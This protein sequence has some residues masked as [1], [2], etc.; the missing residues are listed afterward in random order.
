MLA[1]KIIAFMSIKSLLKT[2]ILITVLTVSNLTL[3]GIPTI[4]PAAL[5]Q[6][7]LEYQKQIEQY[8]NQLQQ[9]EDRIRNS[10]LPK[11]FVWSDLTKTLHELEQKQ[12]ELN[13]LKKLIGN[14]DTFKQFKTVE[15]YAQN[16]CLQ[17]DNNKC[18]KEEF[19]KL[20]EYVKQDKQ[21]IKLATS[22]AY[23]LSVKSSEE[24]VQDTKQLQQ[25]QKKA[26]KATGANEIAQ[27]NNQIVAIQTKQLL[28]QN[29]LLAEQIRQQTIKD[30]LEQ[31]QVEKASAIHNKNVRKNAKR[32]KNDEISSDW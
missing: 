30:K 29:E 12:Q 15:D 8:K 14:V 1:N 32:S 4:D 18:T 27:I 19:D 21:T 28:R 26:Q 5:I 24:I 3:A 9:Y 16:P 11:D 2:C 23:A 6:A 10:K 22:N 13:E 17:V 20:D 31:E 25:L 7:V